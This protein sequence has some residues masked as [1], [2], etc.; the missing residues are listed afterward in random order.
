MYEYGVNSVNGSTCNEKQYRYGSEKSDIC[1]F[2]T[3]INK[4]RNLLVTSQP[5]AEPS[6]I[7]VVNLDQ[8]QLIR[9]RDYNHPPKIDLKSIRRRHSPDHKQ[10]NLVVKTI[11]AGKIR[12]C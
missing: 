2:Q 5:N 10:R 7:E 11:V 8:L 6:L 4:S 1:R 12:R 3:H 9:C